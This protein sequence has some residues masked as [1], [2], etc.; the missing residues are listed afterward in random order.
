[1]SYHANFDKG[2]G[3]WRMVSYGGGSPRWVAIYHKGRDI[4]ISTVSIDDLKD[5]QY[6]VGRMLEEAL[7]D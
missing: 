3:Q 2:A 7:T 5:L 1:M 4:E 6:L